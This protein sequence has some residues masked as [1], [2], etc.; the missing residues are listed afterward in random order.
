VSGGASA[1]A[2]LDCTPDCPPLRILHMPGVVSSGVL[3]ATSNTVSGNLNET[4][5][6][7][8][9]SSSGAASGAASTCFLD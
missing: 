1:A 8:K 7:G 2:I 6:D 4:T 9:E 5:Q 3:T